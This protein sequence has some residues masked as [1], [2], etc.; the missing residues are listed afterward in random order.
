MSS[1]MSFLKEIK[2]E[3]KQLKK[4]AR[5][6]GDNLQA[7]CFTCERITSLDKNCTREKLSDCER[8]VK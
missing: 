3:F 8:G 7:K 1:T 5:L 2:I 4:K 6:K